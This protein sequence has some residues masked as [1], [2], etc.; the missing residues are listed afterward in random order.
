MKRV[1]SVAVLLP[2]YLIVA[3]ACTSPLAPV[4]PVQSIDTPLAAPSTAVPTLLVATTTP[5]STITLPAEP[6]IPS[7]ETYSNDVLGVSLDVPRGHQVVEPQ[8]LGADYGVSLVRPNRSLLLQ[9][10]WLYEETPD[11]M[12]QLIAEQLDQL[13]DLPVERAPVTVGG[14]EGVM[15]SPVPGEV[16]N[17]AIYLPV[18]GRL[19]RLLYAQ[20][21]LDDAGRCLLAGLSFYPPT[22]TLEDLNLTPAADALYDSPPPADEAT[23]AEYRNAD[24]GFSFRYPSESWTLIQNPEGDDHSLSLAYKEMA[25]ALRVK[26]KRL[27]EGADLQLYGGA[28]GDFLPQET[29]SFLGAEVERTARV[30]EDVVQAIHY[31]NTAAIQRGDL[32]FS[33]ALVSNRDPERGAIIPA[34]VQ[35]E[36][37]AILTTFVLDNGAAASTP[38]PESSALAPAAVLLY[39]NGSLERV[40]V[41][42]RGD[43]RGA[44]G[45]AIA[46]PGRPALPIG[47]YFL[48][49]QRDVFAVRWAGHDRGVHSPAFAYLAVGGRWHGG[50]GGYGR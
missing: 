3:T 12:E 15:L 32:L 33:I 29:V 8:Y 1:K 23:W 25:I 20:E 36:A 40:D 21:A 9:M 34:N 14:I 10:A 42:G 6:C 45:E 46:Y 48:V 5:V 7:G 28:A 11:R 38:T 24:Y 13:A 35:A 31:N 50:I 19:Y 44:N 26:F 47:S 30:Y 2:I 37:D 39:R 43:G 49:A 17:T 27:G 41:Q 4:A 22:K 16:A 18:G